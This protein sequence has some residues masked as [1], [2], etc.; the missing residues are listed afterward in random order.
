MVLLLQGTLGFLPLTTFQVPQF[1][2]LLLWCIS[3][4]LL[5]H[6]PVIS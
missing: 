2:R 4:S 6:R 5:L 3:L 1:H